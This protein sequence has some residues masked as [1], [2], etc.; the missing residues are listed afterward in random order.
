MEPIQ[1]SDLEWDGVERGETAFRRKRLAGA[2]DADDDLGCSLYELPPGKRSWP[3]HYHT[4]N[5]EAIYVLA[6]EGQVRLG[7]D[8]HRLRPGMYVPCPPAPEGAHRVVN[9]G[10]DVLRYLAVST[11]TEPD[12]IEYPDSEKIG[13]FAGS[14]PGSRADREIHGYYPTDATVDYWNGEE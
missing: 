3:Y 5:A 10:D 12:V 14:P 7:D 4:G 1:E 11:M 6:G 8:E 2:A 9:D 13:V